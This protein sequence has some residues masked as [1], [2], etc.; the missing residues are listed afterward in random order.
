MVILLWVDNSA[1]ILLLGIALKQSGCEEQGSRYFTTK[2]REIK[3]LQLDL[4]SSKKL[5]K[6]LNFKDHTKREDMVCMP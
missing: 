3:R 1:E 4:T 6:D 2:R 5:I